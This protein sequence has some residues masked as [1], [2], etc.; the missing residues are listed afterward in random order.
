MIQAT[1]HE[2]EIRDAISVPGAGDLVVDAL[3]ALDEAA[4]RRLYWCRPDAVAQADQALE[5]RSG[6]IVI[7]AEGSVPEGALANCRVLEVRDPRAAVARIL[8]LVREL[9]RQPA[10][11][12]TREISADAEISPHAVIEG[13]V[14]IGEGVVIGPFC[15]VGPEVSIGRGSVLHPG[16]RLYPRVSIGEESMIGPNS[17]AGFEFAGFVRDDSGNRVLMPQLAGVIIGS[18]VDIGPLT[19]IG[20]GALKPTILE[21]HVKVGGLTAVAHG[22]RVER[23]AHVTTGVILG[24]SSVIGTEAW[25]GINSSI[26]DG[27]RV[28]SDAL[29]GMDVSVQRDLSDRAVARAALPDIREPKRR[30]T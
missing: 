3:A 14:R 6:C 9:G 5:G 29:V 18:H 16:V 20:S 1:L 19:A 25:I 8:G 23:G 22:V 21:D 4:D 27:R 24:G 11:V 2:Q 15:T 30:A 10:W 13:N 28:G 7:V 26:R 17:V 12:E